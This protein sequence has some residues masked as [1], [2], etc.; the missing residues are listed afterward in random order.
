MKRLNILNKRKIC[1]TK[2]S[3]NSL[4]LKILIVKKT[5]QKFNVFEFIEQ[6]YSINIYKNVA[7]L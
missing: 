1:L 3:K 6:A 2:T 4:P 7:F 5:N